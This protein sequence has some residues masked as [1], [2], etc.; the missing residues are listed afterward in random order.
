MKHLTLSLFLILG[1][2][3]S[4]SADT[5]IFCQSSKADRSMSFTVT[6]NE[7]SVLKVS[8]SGPCDE[9]IANNIT[10][11]QIYLACQ[12]DLGEKFWHS[13]TI[14]RISGAYELFNN[15]T[16]TTRNGSC[17]KASNAF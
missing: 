15:A 12:L 5:R 16:K 7:T 6:F 2:A 17:K 9:V 8:L 4:V 14:N 3:T 11:D 1:L 13:L 10:Q